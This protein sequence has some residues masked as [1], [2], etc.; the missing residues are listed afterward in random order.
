MTWKKDPNL[1]GYIKD[2]NLDMNYDKTNKVN[3]FQ[4][5]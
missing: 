5:S 2:M 1:R 4:K 3:E